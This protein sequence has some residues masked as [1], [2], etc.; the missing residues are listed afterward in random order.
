MKSKSIESSYNARSNIMG[1]VGSL[2][3]RLLDLTKTSNLKIIFIILII[4]LIVVVL[5]LI[6]TFFVLRFGW[7]EVKTRWFNKK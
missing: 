3:S 7:L 1:L 2:G 6:I 4:I 5:I